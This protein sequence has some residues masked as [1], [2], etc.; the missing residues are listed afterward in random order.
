MEIVNLYIKIVTLFYFLRAKK[1]WKS[2]K[3]FKGSVDKIK[4][5]ILALDEILNEHIASWSN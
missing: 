1:N 4:R 2:E 3:N 5:F